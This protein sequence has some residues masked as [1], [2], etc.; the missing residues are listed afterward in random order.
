MNVLLVLDTHLQVD[1]FELDVV[2]VG[3]G[4]SYTLLPCAGPSLVFMYA[5]SGTASVLVPGSAEPNKVLSTKA[6]FACAR[7]MLKKIPINSMR[8]SSTGFSILKC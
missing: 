7:A 4:E 8:S 5:G 6:I 2:D 1:E 3:V